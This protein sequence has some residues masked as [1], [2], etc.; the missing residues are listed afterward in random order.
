[1]GWVRSPLVI[2]G[3]LG[4]LAHLHG[5]RQRTRDSEEADAPDTEATEVGDDP[6]SDDDVL[7]IT[8]AKQDEPSTAT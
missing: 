5:R 4:M 7:D 8:D 6:T 3:G 1:M 2:A